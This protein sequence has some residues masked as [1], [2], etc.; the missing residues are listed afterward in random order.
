MDPWHAR[1]P[2][3][4]QPTSYQRHSCIHIR[5]DAVD[6]PAMKKEHL[7]RQSKEATG[8]DKSWDDAT[9]ESIDWQPHNGESFDSW[10]TNADIQVLQWHTNLCKDG[11]E[12]VKQQALLR[13]PSSGPILTTPSY[14][15]SHSWF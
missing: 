6:M 7:I 9:Y 10:T 3:S 15:G 8:C 1:H 2:I 12:A 5:D 4:W 14:S 11:K 13:G